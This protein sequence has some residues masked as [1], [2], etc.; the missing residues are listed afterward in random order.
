MKTVQEL[1]VKAA[2][3]SKKIQ[4]VQAE[5]THEGAVKK[6]PKAN[7]GGYDG[8]AFDNYWYECRCPVCLKYWYED[9]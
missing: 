5:C 8:P 6:V 1:M 9:Q 2:I 4:R 7:T 3:I